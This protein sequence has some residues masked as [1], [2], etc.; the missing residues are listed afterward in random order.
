MQIVGVD[1]D[2][3]AREAVHDLSVNLNTFTTGQTVKVY[4]V[5]ANDEGE[6]P[7]SPTAQIVVP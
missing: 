1:P 2:F 6:A 4:I 3:V 5:A 7:A